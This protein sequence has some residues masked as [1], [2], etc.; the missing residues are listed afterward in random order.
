MVL[1]EDNL[2]QWEQ[3]F[4]RQFY[5]EGAISLGGNY[6][7][8]GARQLFGMEV[9]GRCHAMTFSRGY[10]EMLI[11]R[12]Y[13]DLHVLIIFRELLRIL[14]CSE[15]NLEVMNSFTFSLDFMQ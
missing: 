3:L 13:T 7:G 4:L 11:C 10:F 8:R 6:P 1:F 12:K 9:V 5:G 2:L 15:N 14:N